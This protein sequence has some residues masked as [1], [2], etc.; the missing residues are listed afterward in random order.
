LNAAVNDVGDHDGSAVVERTGQRTAT[1]DGGFTSENWAGYVVCPSGVSNCAT[2]P[3]ADQVLAVD[4]YWTVPYVAST[5]G[6]EEMAANWVGIGGFGT[7]D[8]IQDGTWEQITPGGSEAVSAWWEMLPGYAEFISLSPNPTI[9]P[10]DTVYAVVS[11]DGTSGSNQ[12]WFFEIIDETTGSSW[13]GAETCASGCYSSSFE[14][15]DWIQESPEAGDTIVQIPA[16]GSFAFSDDEVYLGTPSSATWVSLSSVSASEVYQGFQENS[17]YFDADGVVT[18]NVY[19][20]AGS[21][22][23][24]AQYLVDAYDD[25]GPCCTISP[26]V[27]AVGQTVY[28]HLQLWSPDS[29][30]Y[31]GATSLDL[32]LQIWDPTSG[33]SCFVASE[34]SELSVVSGYAYYPDG[35]TVCPGLNNGVYDYNLL[36]WYGTDPAELGEVGSLPLV[37]SDWQSRLVVSSYPAVTTPMGSPTGIDL[38][39][40]VT[41]TAVASDGS[42]GYSFQWNGLPTGCASSDTA[43]LSCSPTMAGATFVTVAVTDSSGN[44]TLSGSLAYTVRTDP[45][46]SGI[47][48]S[49]GTVDIGQTVTFTTSASGG[50]G[51]YTYTWNGLPTGCASSATPSDSCTPTGAGMFTVTATVADSNGW[52]AT[53]TALP[54]TVATDPMTTAPLASHMSIDLGQPVAFTTTA[55]GGSGSYTYIWSGLPTGCASA[56]SNTIACVPTAFGTDSIIVKVTDSNGYSNTSSP[57]AYTIFSDPTVSAVS[58][59]ANSV[60]IGQT[61]AFSVRASGGAGG[62]SYVWIGLPPGCVSFSSAS[63]QCAPTGAGAFSVNV[64]VTDSSELS[65]TSAILPYTVDSAVTATGAS[66]VGS[67]DVGQSVM[68]SVAAAGGSGGFRYAWSG[69]PLGCVGTAAPAVT[70]VPTAAGAYSVASNITDSNGFVVTTRVLSVTVYSDPVVSSFGV[71]PDSLLANSATTFNASVTGGKAPLTYSYLGLPAGCSSVSVSTFS[72]NPSATGTFTVEV[73]VLDAN[74]FQVTKNTTLTVNPSFLGLPAV[75]GFALVGGGIALAAVAVAVAVLL[76]SRR[77]PRGPTAVPP[78]QQSTPPAGVS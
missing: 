46:L 42:G 30:S 54:Y 71:S 37:S 59:S 36:L 23:F 32:M 40:S 56:N 64:V 22:Y 57:L 28:G 19:N 31:S 47:S 5:S 15:A 77:K 8:L 74:G 29:F 73:V 63:I 12:V 67:L 41:F 49:L 21:A 7:E 51:G 76:L 55:T 53:G 4:A 24:Y 17:N 61:V 66:S 72:C 34:S 13:A 3:S 62:Y 35:L 69:L 6:S 60:D 16:F 45:T 27:A 20:N 25:S 50:S 2:P 70:C 78:P 52:T 48:A 26:D 75:D 14:T 33:E 44:T 18:S 38:G 39:Q 9:S 1:G 68:F 58:T 43:Q 11:F 10:T 65:V